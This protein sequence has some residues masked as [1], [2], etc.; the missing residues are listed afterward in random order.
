MS[1]K[2]I[3]AIQD[4]VGLQHWNGIKGNLRIEL[5]LDKVTKNDTIRNYVVWEPERMLIVLENLEVQKI[6][7]NWFC[8]NRKTLTQKILNLF[9]KRKKAMYQLNF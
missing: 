8:S 1:D 3:I 9:W 6:F 5:H 4:S 2:S 7:E